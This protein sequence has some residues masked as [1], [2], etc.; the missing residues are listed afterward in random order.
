MASNNSTVCWR[1]TGSNK[2]ILNPFL[3]TTFNL[4]EEQR[5]H[6]NFTWDESGTKM[7]I[8]DVDL[9]SK[10]V[11]KNHFGHE[12][13]R[14]FV[15][16]LNMYNFKKT[17]RDSTCHEYINAFFKKGQKNLLS[18]IKRKSV[19]KKDSL[20]DV[21]SSLAEEEMTMEFEPKHIKKPRVSELRDESDRHLEFEISKLKNENESTHREIQSLRNELDE[22]WNFANMLDNQ[23]KKLLLQLSAQEQE[24]KRMSRQVH[25]IPRLDSQ[26]DAP[27]IPRE[28]IQQGNYYAQIAQEGYDPSQFETITR[29]QSQF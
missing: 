29:D 27:Y 15:R 1:K 16:Q 21:N 22:M 17:K 2:S 9:F 14:S 7:L 11:L 5:Y 4:L 13:F 3:E 19:N 10:T 20:D 26:R 28:Q 18:Q 12:K 6:P 23:N 8:A 25:Q 24:M